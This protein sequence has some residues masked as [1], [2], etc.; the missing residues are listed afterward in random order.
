MTRR[1]TIIGLEN[2]LSPGQ[3][4]CTNAGLLLI[5]SLGTNFSEIIFEIHTFSFKQMHSKT[6]SAK[7]RTCCLGLNV[8]NEYVNQINEMWHSPT[9][10]RTHKNPTPQIVM[11]CSNSELP[12]CYQKLNRWWFISLT[13]AV[14]GEGLYNSVVRK[15]NVVEDVLQYQFQVGPIDCLRY[16]VFVNLSHAV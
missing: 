12:G 14:K 16:G 15:Q 10:Q 3:R 9:D 13:D 11:G 4:I 8:L 1:F 7:W 6:P 5:W 2:G